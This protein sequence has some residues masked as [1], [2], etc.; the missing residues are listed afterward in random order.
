[1]DDATTARRVITEND[2][3]DA[4][5]RVLVVAERSGGTV[6]ARDVEELVTAALAGVGVLIPPPAP[7]PGTCTALFPDGDGYWVQCQ[8][9]PG[10]TGEYHVDG[11]YGW[12][13]EH[14]DAVPAQG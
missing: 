10:H 4:C 2:Y 12:T 6:R 5:A 14:P 8:E 13:D 11:D 3:E 9:D 7:E 1:M